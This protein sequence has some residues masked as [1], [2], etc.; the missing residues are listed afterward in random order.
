M[1][2]TNARNAEQC[3]DVL[4]CVMMRRDVLEV[5]NIEGCNAAA[6]RGCAVL[7]LGQRRERSEACFK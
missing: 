6:L 7:K 1:Y 5:E 4:Q 3:C 2:G